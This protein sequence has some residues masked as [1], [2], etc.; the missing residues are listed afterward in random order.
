MVRLDKVGGDSFKSITNGGTNRGLNSEKMILFWLGIYTGPSWTRL[1]TRNIFWYVGFGPNIFRPRSSSK[2]IK[3]AFR[4]SSKDS[5]LATM[6]RSKASALRSS[7]RPRKAVR[8]NGYGI[9]AA[10]WLMHITLGRSGSHGRARGEMAPRC[11]RTI[12]PAHVAVINQLTIPM[13]LRKELKF[14]K[15]YGSNGN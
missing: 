4:V 7:G 11:A 12:V 8:S 15:D 14:G 10:C 6:V 5:S 3:E 1:R 9:T 13:A 2:T